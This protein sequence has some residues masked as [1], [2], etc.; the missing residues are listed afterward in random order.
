MLL[1]LLLCGILRSAEP[2]KDA[3]SRERVAVRTATSGSRIYAHISTSSSSSSLEGSVTENMS[4]SWDILELCSVLLLS[5]FASIDGRIV[6]VVVLISPLLLT[7][8]VTHVQYRRTLR[9][10]H[11]PKQPARLPYTF[12][13]VGSAAAFNRDAIGFI[14]SAM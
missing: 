9:N 2:S 3:Y 11:G 8:L 13:A 4:R 12:P 6:T 1:A 7:N 5:A 10:K 14:A